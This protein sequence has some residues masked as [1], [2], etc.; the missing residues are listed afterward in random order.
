MTAAPTLLFWLVAAAGCGLTGV[1]I[2]LA[3]LGIAVSTYPDHPPSWPMAIAPPVL[4]TLAGAVLGG[5]AGFAFAPWFTGPAGPAAGQAG[6]GIG[7]V[8]AMGMSLATS[9]AFAGVGG[10]LAL[11]SAN[12]RER[13]PWLGRAAVVAGFLAIAAVGANVI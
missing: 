6:L 2:V 13:A 8:A 12:V 7:L 1:M 5:V 10:I 9:F 3:T 11:A 4:A